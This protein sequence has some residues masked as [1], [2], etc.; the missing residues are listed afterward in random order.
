[1]LLIDFEDRDTGTPKFSDANQKKKLQLE[2]LINQYITEDVLNTKSEGNH[3]NVLSSVFFMVQSMEAWILSQPNVIETCLGSRNL[4]NKAAFERR[5]TALIKSPTS[6]TKK[7][8]DVLKQLLRYFKV[9]RQGKIRNMEYSKVKHASQML[10]QL[11]I[12]QL[13]Q[14]F[15][16]VKLIVE[17]IN[18]L[19]NSKV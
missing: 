2:P 8:D 6:L 7:P 3:S 11:D 12:Q 14:D 19:N 5:K 13:M 18:Q 15:E 9:E 10:R 1:M 4:D 16:D 17:R